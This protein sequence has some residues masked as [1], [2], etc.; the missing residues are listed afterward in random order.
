MSE[1]KGRDLILFTW[2]FEPK[3]PEGKF[4]KVRKAFTSCCQ[5]H[6]QARAV[7]WAQVSLGQDW[8]K[9]Y[10]DPQFVSKQVLAEG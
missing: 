2:E 6:S 7:C 1:E 3:D 5:P 8:Q 10:K 4:K 9:R